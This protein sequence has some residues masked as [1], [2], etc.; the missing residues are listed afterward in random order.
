VAAAAAPAAQAAL[1]QNI[2][3]TAHNNGGR[4]FMAQYHR[5]A[6]DNQP[7]KSSQVKVFTA[8]FNSPGKLHINQV[9]SF[10]ISSTPNVYVDF[11]FH[12]TIF[13]TLFNHQDS[14]SVAILA[15]QSNT[16]SQEFFTI[17]LKTQ[18]LLVHLSKAC[19]ICLNLSDHQSRTSFVHLLTP[20]RACVIICHVSSTT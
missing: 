5:K 3:Q 18:F 6:S 10:L 16:I 8:Q 1:H 7:H 15:N 14:I 17:F 4:T 11:I 9:S 13:Q 2:D 12:S 19:T 20:F